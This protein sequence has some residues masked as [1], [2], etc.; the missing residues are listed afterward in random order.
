MKSS[1]KT[2][3]N[4]IIA[5]RALAWSAWIE[6]SG[7]VRYR[8]SF[9][10][11]IVVYT[12]VLAFFMMSNSGQSLI[13]KY[14]SSDY[15]SLLFAGYIAW[16]FANAAL[17][18]S[19]NNT[20]GELSR[21]TFYRKIKAQCPLPLLQLGEL[22]STV[23]VNCIVAAAVAFIGWIAWDLHLYVSISSIIAIIICSLGMYGMGLILD[24]VAIRYK[25]VGSLLFLF[26]LGL[27]FVT[28]T[29][30][31]SSG[32]LLL[33]RIIPLTACNDFI[34]LSM[35]GGNPSGA[36]TTLFFTS[37]TWLIVGNIVF[38]LLFTKAKQNGNLLFY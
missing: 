27:L 5:L 16:T 8:F 24:G 18:T 2:H 29:L 7:A 4:V 30:P 35:T 34:R 13:T 19:V 12:A 37:L 31:S 22:C 17:V 9:I 33:T 1:N 10:S 15:K 38:H 6:L 14:G 11:D 20:T 23:F 28:D 26:Q 21:G 32:I 3:S 25:R 36:F